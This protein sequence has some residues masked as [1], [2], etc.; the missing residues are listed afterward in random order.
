[1]LGANPPAAAGWYGRPVGSPDRDRR[2]GDVDGEDVATVE[3]RPLLEMFFAIA[4][5]AYP[6]IASGEVRVIQAK[7]G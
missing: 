6:R 4:R 7:E 5:H 3:G 2:S 1:M